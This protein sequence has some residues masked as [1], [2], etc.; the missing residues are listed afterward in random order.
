[1][2]GQK[3]TAAASTR[4]YNAE[5]LER[6]EILPKRE[7]VVEWNSSMKM[8]EFRGISDHTSRWISGLD[9]EDAYRV[10]QVRSLFATSNPSR[11]SVLHFA[12]F[13]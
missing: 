11:L 8:M 7:L 1:M 9:V 5:M 10:E 4:G 12:G 2:A 3:P 13:V 6:H